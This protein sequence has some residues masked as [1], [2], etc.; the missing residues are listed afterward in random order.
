[1][2]NKNNY[3]KFLTMNKCTRGFGVKPTPERPGKTKKAS[4]ARRHAALEQSDKGS[5]ERRDLIHG[6][7]QVNTKQV[8]HKRVIKGGG[9]GMR[10]G[11]VK[12]RGRNVKNWK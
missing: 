12:N 3:K 6:G 10:A 9:T 5:S 2:Q 7:V 8:H 11:C 1:M 4:Q